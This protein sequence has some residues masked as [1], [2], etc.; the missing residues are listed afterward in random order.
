MEYDKVS[1]LWSLGSSI[2][3]IDATLFLTLCRTGSTS[4]TSQVHSTLSCG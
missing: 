1:G 2:V 3:S 4:V